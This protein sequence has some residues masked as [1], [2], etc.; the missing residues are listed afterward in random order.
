M[1]QRLVV[2]A[3]VDRA[4]AGKHKPQGKCEA[5]TAGGAS[6]K[7]R[8]QHARRDRDTRRASGIRARNAYDARQA[9]FAVENVTH[10]THTRRAHGLAAIPTVAHRVHIGMDGTLH[11]VLL[12]PIETF[13]TGNCAAKILRFRPTSSARFCCFGADGFVLSVR[14]GC[15]SGE[16]FGADCSLVAGFWSFSFRRV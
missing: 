10:G 3:V 14:P 13:R 2:L 6:R 5:W 11:G 15:L 4:E 9:F 16:F 8:R 1:N 7:G 12:S